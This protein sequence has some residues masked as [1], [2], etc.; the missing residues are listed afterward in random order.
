MTDKKKSHEE[1]VLEDLKELQDEE[2]GRGNTQDNTEKSS[3][4]EGDSKPSYDELMDML[5]RSQANLENFRKQTEKRIDEIRSYS[6]S[7]IVSKF[8]PVL[9]SFDLAIQEV[10][11]SGSA[12]LKEGLEL[13][14]KQLQ[15]TLKDLGVEEIDCSSMFDPAIHE[16][17]SKISDDSEEG[18]ILSV[19]QRGYMLNDKVLRAA[20]VQV[21]S[22]KQQSE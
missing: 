7:D 12:Q 3:D 5:K 1:E 8:I 22:G 10:T 21:S 4:K 14:Q 13:I 17:L 6:K 2:N 20:R 16:A 9:D 18:T 19:F 11:V 15:S